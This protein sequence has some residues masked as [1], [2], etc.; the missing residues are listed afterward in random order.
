MDI[1]VKAVSSFYFGEVTNEHKILVTESVLG[2]NF[3]NILHFELLDKFQQNFAFVVTTPPIY[4]SYWHVSSRRCHQQRK[5]NA[6]IY[7]G[8]TPYHLSFE[9]RV[10]D[11]F[12]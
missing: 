8:D 4:S 10:T 6:L 7:S 2:N 12:S 1:K 5:Q 3:A 9:I 11:I